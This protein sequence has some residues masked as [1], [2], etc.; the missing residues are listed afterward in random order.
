MVLRAASAKHVTEE[1]YEWS[2][3]EE[4]DGGIPGLEEESQGGWVPWMTRNILVAWFLKLP[5][6]AG[7]VICKTSSTCGCLYLVALSFLLFLP[8]FF[9][10]SFSSSLFSLP[11]PFL[12]SPLCSLSSDPPC[13]R[14]LIA[15]QLGGTLQFFFFIRQLS[16]PG[17]CSQRHEQKVQ[18][19]LWP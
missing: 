13:L 7:G 8:F 6:G 4:K 11:S 9:P 2:E 18:G 10:P 16:F 5:S 1:G 14:F 15:W 12:S 19:F 17:Q 3:A